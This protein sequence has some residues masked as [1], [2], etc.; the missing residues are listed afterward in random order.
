MSVLPN[1][2]NYTKLPNPVPSGTNTISVVS[3]PSNGSTFPASS[4][5]QIDLVSRGYLVPNSLYIRYKSTITSATTASNMKGT[6]VYTPFLKSEVICGSQ[7]IDSISNY[8]QLSNYLINTRLNLAQKLGRQ[9]ALGYLDSSSA[10]DIAKMNGRLVPLAGETYTVSAPLFNILTNCETLIPLELIPSLRIQLTLDTLSNMFSVIGGAT[11]FNITNFE[12]CYDIVNFS[13]EV[14][15]MVR[16]MVDSNGNITL[17][18]QSYASAGQNLASG[19]S[20]TAEL[21][22]NFRFSSLKS[23]AINIGRSTANTFLDSVD[24]TQNNGSF[25]FVVGGQSYPQREIST[26]LNKAGV[27]SELASFWGSQSEIDAQNFS[28]STAEFVKVSSATAGDTTYQVPGKFWVGTNLESLSSSGVLL[29]G[30]STN[31]SPISVRINLGTATA[32]AH[33][34]QLICLYDALLQINVD[35]QQLVVK[36]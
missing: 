17:K 1:E 25:Q 27:L 12:L 10:P 20:G 34:I 26:V 2:I 24:C 18:S 16:Q 28:I 31:A 21:I 36:Q 15:S 22:Y 33:V 35:T 19:S 7:V 32:E 13:G 5:I 30:I 8:H 3:L 11:A 4:I 23:V 29:S 14:N 6:P 9:Y